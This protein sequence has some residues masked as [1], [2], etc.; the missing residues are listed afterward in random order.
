[1][2][3]L[4]NTT[5]GS[6]AIK[7]RTTHHELSILFLFDFDIMNRISNHDGS[8]IRLIKATP[9]FIQAVTAGY[10]SVLEIKMK[11]LI[12]TH[13]LWVLEKGSIKG[14]SYCTVIFLFKLPIHLHIQNIN[15]TLTLSLV[16]ALPKSL[17]TVHITKS[18]QEI[19]KINFSCIPECSL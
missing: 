18:Y 9:G 10:H 8:D 15:L 19:P 3:S 7:Q 4:D 13:F 2:I 1:M 12:T 16:F 17:Q 5:I 14:I 11:F 6:N